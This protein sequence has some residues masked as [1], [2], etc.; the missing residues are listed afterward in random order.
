LHFK[1]T[2]GLPPSPLEPLELLLL[3]EP[4]LLVLEP[5]LLLD[6]PL[7]PLLVLLE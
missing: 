2:Q 7:E 5:P 1:P 4:P 3:E 6:A